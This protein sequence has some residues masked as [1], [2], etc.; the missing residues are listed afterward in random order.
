[1]ED[2]NIESMKDKIKVQPKDRRDS[3]FLGDLNNSVTG[4]IK[5]PTNQDDDNSPIDAADIASAQQPSSVSL[6]DQTYEQLNSRVQQRVDDAINALTDVKSDLARLL[7][8]DI[9]HAFANDE[10]IHSFYNAAKTGI[11]IDNYNTVIGTINDLKRTFKSK[12]K[13]K[14]K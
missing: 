7:T 6:D 3:E 14:S 13:S 9:S 5:Q 12:S 2:N 8:S 4:A 11:T 1:M 10:T